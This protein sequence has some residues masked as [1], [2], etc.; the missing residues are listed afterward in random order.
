MFWPV[1]DQTIRGV[2]R[3]RCEKKW[4]YHRCA[5]YSPRTH[6]SSHKKPPPKKKKKNNTNNSSK[7]TKNNSNN[8]NKAKQNANKNWIVQ[9]ELWCSSQTEPNQDHPNSRRTAT[10]TGEWLLIAARTCAT[11]GSTTTTT[12]WEAQTEWR[13]RPSEP[14]WG[15]SSGN[16]TSAP[17]VRCIWSPTGHSKVPTIPA[18]SVHIP[19][20]QM[21][22]WQTGLGILCTRQPTQCDYPGLK[23]EPLLSS[24]HTHS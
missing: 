12:T 20:R 14:T 3:N 22:C 2:T 10:N 5:C 4:R 16:Q 19:S 13:R 24:S 6:C 7:H 21:Y 1:K 17:A 11:A 18:A 9:K 23:F 8:G 15:Y